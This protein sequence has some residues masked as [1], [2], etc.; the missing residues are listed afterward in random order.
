MNRITANLI[1]LLATLFLFSCGGDEQEAEEASQE[2]DCHNSNPSEALE[3]SELDDLPE[4]EEEPQEEVRIPDPNGVY[5][6][7][8]DENGNPY[9]QTQM[10][11][12]VVMGPLENYRSYWRWNECFG[13]G[14]QR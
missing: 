14:N 7:T 5:L 6:P 8:G 2:R 13:R 1:F 10:V 11:L 9:T 4:V 12:S 3:K